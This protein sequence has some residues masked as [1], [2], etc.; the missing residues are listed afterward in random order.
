M[1]RAV[2]SSH[3]YRY[4]AL[5]LVRAV[6]KVSMLVLISDFFVV[7]FPIKLVSL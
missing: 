2:I 7:V 4:I 6:R 3:L 5:T 1:Q